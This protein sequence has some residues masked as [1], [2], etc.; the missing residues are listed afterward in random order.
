[1]G[2]WGERESRI[3]KKGRR[4][5]A[6]VGSLS[7]SL[8]PFP[9]AGMHPIIC[10]VVLTS[11]LTPS[12]Y[13]PLYKAISSICH[14]LSPSPDSFPWLNEIC[15]SWDM[16][17]TFPRGRWESTWTD[18][19]NNMLYYLSVYILAQAPWMRFW[20]WYTFLNFSAFTLNVKCCYLDSAVLWSW[21]PHCSLRS[22]DL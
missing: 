15:L 6:K 1:M 10:P 19:R 22:P 5:K 4:Q 3:G 20:F 2:K 8:F 18:P 9:L 21:H 17:P 16:T 13:Y 11:P 12:S 7:L 14:Q